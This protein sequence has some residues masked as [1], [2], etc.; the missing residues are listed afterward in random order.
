MDLE[1][2]I[3]LAALENAVKFK[4]RANPGAIIGKLMSIDSSVKERMKDVNPRIQEIVE[5][6]N[7][8]GR[9]SQKNKLL[10]LKPDYEEQQREKKQK[11]KEERSDLPALKDAEAGKVVTRMPPG[12]SK[13]AHAG[14][15]VSFLINYMYA[16]KY[17]GKCILRFDDTNPEVESQEFADAIREDLLDYLEVRP[18]RIVYTSDDMDRF[19]RYA[20]ELIRKGEA[21]T[22]SCQDISE[23]RKQMQGCEHREQG[24]EEN[25]AAWEKMK[26]G[27][28][29]TALR[30]KIDMGHKNA[31]M[32]DPVI[33]RVVTATHYRQG[34]KYKVWPLYDFASAVEDG[35][36]G[37]T[38]VLRSNEF[39]TRIELQEHI[40]D[41]LGLV[42]PIFV[43]YGRSS[44]TGAVTQGRK[45][46]E[47]IESGEYIGWDD[48]R[49]VTLR[50]LR[51]RGIV[52]ESLYHLAKVCGLSKQATNIDFT[53]ISA[54]NKK[55]LDE[56]AKRFFF[57][58]DPVSLHIKGAPERELELDMHPKLDLGKRRFSTNE[59]YYIERRDFENMA[60]G[61]FVRLIDNLNLVFRGRESEYVNDDYRDFKEKGECIIHFLPADKSQYVEAE[62]MMPNTN[63]VSGFAENAVKALKEGDVI[64]F[65][66]FGFCRLDSIENGVY[67]FWFAH[68]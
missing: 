52:K 59:Y 4:G 20:E 56:S 13:Y 53:M 48:P 60:D 62:I 12:P 1:K 37:V 16:R 25:L 5:E 28:G 26:S 66:R 41:L 10:E 27:E 34:E 24:I 55:V 21:Y 11:N 51:R 61:E 46:R 47:L 44:I 64:Q 40:L 43:H 36:N 58:S 45:I 6:V 2:E 50:A 17:E 7:S 3:W 39:D 42:K 33:Y 38:H 63:L 67:R 15:A 49:L 65:Q 35:L 18:D 57:I 68:Q 14:H 23:K 31:V 54:E 22:C 19:I 8:M 29:G 32:R 30:L 9:D